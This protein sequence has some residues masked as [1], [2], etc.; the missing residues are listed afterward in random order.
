MEIY[1]I[2]NQVNG[3]Q[4][5]G[6]TLMGYL[7][8]FHAHCFNPKSL[9]GAAIKEHGAEKFIVEVLETLEDE[10]DRSQEVVWI[11]KLNTW[12]PNGYNA[13]S[14]TGKSGAG[15]KRI[16]P[17]KRKRNRAISLTDAQYAQLKELAKAAGE[18]G[19]SAYIVSKHT[20]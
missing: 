10:F 17:A 16:D 19:V 2:T 14:G 15:R 7:R 9:I 20:W 12:Q 11:D 8:R 13:K 4:Y 3:K 5:V 18:P 1:C 6:S